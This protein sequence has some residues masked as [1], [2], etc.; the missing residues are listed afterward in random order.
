MTSILEPRKGAYVIAGASGG[1]GYIVAR[2]LAKDGSFL[3]LQGNRNYEKLENLASKLGNVEMWKG[4]L[5]D[6]K[7]LAE[8]QKQTA[9]FIKKQKRAAQG[10]EVKFGLFNGIGMRARLDQD[11]DDGQVTKLYIDSVEINYWIP[12]GIAE[13]FAQEVGNSKARILFFSTEQTILRPREKRPFWMPKQTLENYAIEMS[14]KYP[15][16]YINTILPGTLDIG[17]FS[18]DEKEAQENGTLVD[19]EKAL[20]TCL[21]YLTSTE[22]TGKRI[23]LT[24]ERRETTVRKL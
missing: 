14:K 12:I 7:K 24:A 13:T 23:L 6:E 1:L 16:I 20:K 21:E 15:S 9:D 2:Q 22:E 5:Q 8:F 19:R 17:R 3:L 18:D 10:G 11:I 4:D